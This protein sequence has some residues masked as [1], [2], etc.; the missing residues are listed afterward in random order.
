MDVG[1]EADVY[2][3]G[4][5][6]YEPL[7]GHPPFRAATTLQTL[8]LVRSREPVPPRELQPAT[9]RDLQTI[10]LKCLEKE[11]WKRY[12]TAALLADDLTRF[13][14]HEPIRRARWAPGPAG[15]VGRRNPVPAGL[16]AVLVLTG[17]FALT[18]I[19]L[20]WRK[21]NALARSLSVANRQSEQRRQRAVDAQEC[22][23]AGRR[24]SPASRR[25]RTPGTLSVERRGRECGL[26]TPERRIRPGGIS[27]RRHRNTATGSGDTCTAS[28][29]APTP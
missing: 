3:L 28:W 2:S 26:A 14:N 24:R 20:Q 1:P 22:A 23:R 12:T 8:D 29:T 27:R 18:A 17:L 5:I 25:G 4:A 10:C 6:V 16:L 9:L 15:A 21:A 7:T 13:L 11:P 19:L